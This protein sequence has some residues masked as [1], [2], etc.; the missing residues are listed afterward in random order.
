MVGYKNPVPFVDD[1]ARERHEDNKMSSA[2]DYNEQTVYFAFIDV[3]GF[4]KAFDDY[5]ITD[6]KAGC[7]EQFRDVFNYYFEVMNS[8]DFM[9][10]AKNT[11]CYVGQTSDSLYFYTPRLDMLVDFIKVFLHFNLYAMSKGV[12]FRGG[13]A[14]GNLFV[15]D[16]H[17][18]Y[19]ESVICAYLLESSIARNPLIL[20]DETT[21]NEIKKFD[22]M[23]PF[24]KDKNNRYYLNVFPAE[25][26]DMGTIFSSSAFEIKEIDYGEIEK[27]IQR[28]KKI[29]EYDARN[30]DK[31]IFLLDSYYEYKKNHDSNIKVGV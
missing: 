7:I 29:F 2:G 27:N 3:L 14:K 28:N 18:F 25:E 16:P 31:Y 23:G 15:K 1:T 9:K 11:G 24:L 8:T 20:L 12:F 17:Q 21:Y 19:G 10:Q 4:K 13:I 30:Y 26:Y 22:S 6:C 5:K